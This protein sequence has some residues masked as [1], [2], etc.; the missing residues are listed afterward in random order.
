MNC[1]STCEILTMHFCQLLVHFIR[2]STGK[3]SVLL[4]FRI[5]K[6]LM[7]DIAEEEEVRGDVMFLFCV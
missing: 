7:E 5:D 2:N 1:R 3:M 6:P 4:I